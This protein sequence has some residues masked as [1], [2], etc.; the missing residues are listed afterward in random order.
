MLK[1]K[2]KLM[3]G[4]L[5][6]NSKM[7]FPIVLVLAVAVTV[8]FALKA[9]DNKRQEELAK[10]S[11]PQESVGVVEATAEPAVEIPVTENTIPEIQ[12]LIDTYYCAY[13]IGDIETIKTITNY[14]D[15]TEGLRIQAM[16]EYVEDYPVKTIYTR[17]GPVQDS[18]LAY[19]HFKMK[20]TNFEDT[21]SGMETFYICK[22]ADGSYYLN[23]GEVSEEELKFIEKVAAQEDVV[24][25]YNRVN[26]ECSDTLKANE[27]L[28][29]YIQ[30]VVKEVQK[31][32][33]EALAEQKQNDSE[34]VGEP[35]GE[36]MQ[37]GDADTGNNET[38]EPTTP[39]QDAEP[40]YA[41]ATTTVNVRVSDS[42][43]SDKVDK[44]SGGTKVE[45]LEQKVN[46]WS[47]V[48]FGKTEGYIKSEFLQLLNVASNA[49]VIGTVTATSNVNV[50]M[51]PDE[52]ADRMGVLSGGETVDLLGRENGW[53]KIDYSGQI[54][55]VKE[56]FVQ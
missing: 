46:G 32:T 33:G 25:L 55:Y 8:L 49:E 35:E 10:E 50:R 27:E 17:P 45:V 22:K 37:E 3:G 14:L 48:K 1:E 26:V 40:I 30:E 9:K 51:N 52:T 34:A 54:G 44:V 6:K 21:V 23:E 18:F 28:F 56:D 47:K 16:S 13:A 15:E 4:F 39:V 12:Q 43:Q 2:M 38:A 24:E 7:V 41:K 53:C 31:S 20:V 29:Y 42:E 5:V 11:M 36:V 19:V